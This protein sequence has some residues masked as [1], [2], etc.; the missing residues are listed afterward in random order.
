MFDTSV[1]TIAPA[2]SAAS[3]RSATAEQEP[4]L[5]YVPEALDL[6]LVTARPRSGIHAHTH[7]RTHIRVRADIIGHFKPCMT[8]IY[9]HI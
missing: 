7:T 9:L 2:A 6:S 5:S 4:G 3:V 8:D 1:S